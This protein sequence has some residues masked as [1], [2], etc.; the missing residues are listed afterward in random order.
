[1]TLA[2]NARDAVRS[3]AFKFIVV[4][5]LILALS[6]PLLFVYAL[7]YEREQYARKA[8]SEV[9][10]M[11][12]NAQTVSGPY[13]IVPFESDREV[14]RNNQTEIKT[15]RRLLAFLPEDLSING[16]IDSDVRKR[17]IFEIPVYRSQ[18]SLKGKF[19][20]PD[21]QRA[22]QSSD[23]ILWSKAELVVLITDVRGIKRSATIDI[24]GSSRPFR[25]SAGVNGTGANGIHVPIIETQAKAGFAFAFDLALNG[26]RSLSVVPAGGETDVELK[27]DWAHPS[28][29]GQ[30][31]PETRNISDAGFDAKWLIPRLARGQGQE[32]VINQV[33]QLQSTQAFGVGLYQPVRFYSLAQRALKYALGFVAIAFLAVFVME[34]QSR[35]RVHWIQ[36]IFVGLALVIFYVLLIGTAEHVGFDLGYAGA[37][38]AT[39]L[40][41]AAYFGTV[42]RSVWRGAVLFALLATIYALLYLLLRLEDYALLVGSIAAFVLIGTVMFATRNVDWSRAAYAVAPPQRPSDGDSSDGLK[43]GT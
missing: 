9:G 1:M 3:P 20:P 35:Q 27:S 29:N 18:L 30:F 32:R 21:W 2:D 34:I 19:N 33:R 42:V 43:A 8:T 24:A 7:V 4:L 17:G 14:R 25:A 37:A 31:L 22:A 38:L 6:I 41:I 23:R 15:I 11:W 28:F 5:I 12:A 39:S 10:Q 16:E 40:L 36:Y 13:L 26:S